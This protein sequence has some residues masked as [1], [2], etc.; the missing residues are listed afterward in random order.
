MYRQVTQYDKMHSS[1]LVHNW[2]L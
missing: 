2:G 1:A